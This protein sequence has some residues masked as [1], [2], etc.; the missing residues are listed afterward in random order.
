V[1]DVGL[2]FGPQAKAAGLIQPYK[3]ST[4]DSIPAEA[5]DADGFWYGDYYGVMSL[6]VNTD[7]VKNPPKEWVD[8]LKPEYK[9]QVALAGDPRG[10]AQAIN[11]VYAAALSN[12]GSLDDAK[13]GLD[14]FAKLNQSGNFV[15][16]IAKQ[17][18]I[19][20]GETPIVLRWDYNALAD[21][22]SLKGNPK[23]E[24]HVPSQ[25]V[26]AGVYVQAISAFA[27]HPNAAK[28]WEEYLYSDAGQLGWLKGYCHP[29]RYT[30]LAKRNAVPSDL[31]AK[32][33]PASVYTEA[34]FPTLD[35]YNKAS[36]TITKG[37]D[38]SVGA[39]V[40]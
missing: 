19:A 21:V 38:A 14:F 23:V 20:K 11:G 13:P 12:G 22:D 2:A 7:V 3:V 24:V 4:W 10:S 26:L 31:S 39:N 17:G 40:K 33:P 35:Q 9:G 5:K 18:T 15:P 30:D 34:K 36:D 37:W 29:I 6:E 25:G 27:P 28:L 8:L 32:L 1:I 16:V